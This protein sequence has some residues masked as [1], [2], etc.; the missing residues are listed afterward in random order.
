MIT[1][2]G[3]TSRAPFEEA[4]EDW[5]VRLCSIFSISLIVELQDHMASRLSIAKRAASDNHTLRKGPPWSSDA[6]EAKPSLEMF[7]WIS[8]VKESAPLNPV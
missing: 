7:L 8:I 1:D 2:D 5:Q 6:Q 4:A 3:E